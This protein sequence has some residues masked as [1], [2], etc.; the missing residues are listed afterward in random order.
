MSNSESVRNIALRW[1]SEV[2]NERKTETIYE[3]LESESVGHQE[4]D[5]EIVGPKPFAEFQQTFLKLLP[6][7]EAEI[8]D[9]VAEAG[10]VCVHWRF[11]GTHTGSGLGLEP[12][13]KKVNVRGMTW[14]R[15]QNG[16]IVE[17]WDSWN[18]QALIHTLSVRQ[19]ES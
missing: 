1:F 14:F 7:M 13:G 4:G 11:T 16:R 5:I 10:K 12:T 9:T 19:P 15:I 2:W 18:Q 3:L 8:L 17:G 6:D